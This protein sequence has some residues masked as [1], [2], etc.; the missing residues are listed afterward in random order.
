MFLKF[1][2]SIWLADFNKSVHISIKDL[3]FQT[4][5]VR[6]LEW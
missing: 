5:D 1:F 6:L 3:D 4:K 2:L